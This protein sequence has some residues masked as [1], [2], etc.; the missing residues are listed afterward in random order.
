[1]HRLSVKNPLPSFPPFF[2]SLLQW[3]GIFWPWKS[4]CTMCVCVCAGKGLYEYVVAIYKACNLTLHWSLKR[5]TTVY[6]LVNYIVSCFFAQGATIHF[7]KFAKK[8]EGPVFN[9][10]LYGFSIICNK[11]TSKIDDYH[12]VLVT[13]TRDWEILLFHQC[14]G[15]ESFFRI[16]FGSTIFFKFGFGYGFGS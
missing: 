15:S 7:F 6:K 10:I 16:G 8:I 3:Q 1:M 11:N 12:F 13:V 4:L 5:G 2:C 9:Y 14:C